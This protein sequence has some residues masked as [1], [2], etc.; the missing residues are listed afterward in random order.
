MRWCRWVERQH[1]Q[2]AYNVS[3]NKAENL[4]EVTDDVLAGLGR[5]EATVSIVMGHEYEDAH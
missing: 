2:L 1:T 3:P 4:K 5:E